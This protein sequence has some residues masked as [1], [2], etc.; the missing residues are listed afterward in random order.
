MTTFRDLLLIVYINVFTFKLI[1]NSIKISF[2]LKIYL[3]ET[4]KT[5]QMRR[6]LKI[7][8]ILK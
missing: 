2:N 3:F 7:K 1:S 5:K 6:K 4:L 8:L